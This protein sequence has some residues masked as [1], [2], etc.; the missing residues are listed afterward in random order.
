MFRDGHRQGRAWAA[1][2]VGVLA[3]VITACGSSSSATTTTGSSTSSTARTVPDVSKTA[4]ALITPADI[5]TAMA[6]TVAE[7]TATIRGAVTT[8][9]YRAT[10]LADSV[11]IEYN[12][13]ASKA[14]YTAEQNTVTSHKATPVSF[15]GL[16]QYAYFFI[17]SSGAR[18]VYTVV[19]LQGKL[20]VVV[21]S[22][23]SLG[24]TKTLTEEIIYKVDAGAAAAT[25]TT[26]TPTTTTSG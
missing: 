25:S 1:A 20:Q 22:T 23:T 19:T 9:T 8:C 12:V 17:V 26:T 10:N 6:T 4:C 15:P 7:P 11:I 16:G 3:V 2:A 5:Q 13:D 14:T 24:Q 21:T 18:S